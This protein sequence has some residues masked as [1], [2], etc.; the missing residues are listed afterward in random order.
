M[1]ENEISRYLPYI[2]EGIQEIEINL[3]EITM[4]LLSSFLRLLTH[5]SGKNETLGEVPLYPLALTCIPRLVSS[6]AVHEG[7]G[8]RGG[9]CVYPG[10]LRQTGRAESAATG[11]LRQLRHTGRGG[12]V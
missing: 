8:D 9:E 3:Q 12:G 6:G 2:L 10:R 5:L 4:P 1:R 7:V 11:T